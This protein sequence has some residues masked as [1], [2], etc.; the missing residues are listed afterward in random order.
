MTKKEHLW[1]PIL[2]SMLV[3]VF[4][5]QLKLLQNKLERLCLASLFGQ[6]YYFKWGQEPTL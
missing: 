6:V 3:N 1:D 4:L 5:I 2:M